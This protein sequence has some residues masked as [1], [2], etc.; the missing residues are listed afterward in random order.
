MISSQPFAINFKAG[1]VSKP[2]NITH[3]E[4]FFSVLDCGVAV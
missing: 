3:D 2:Q 4:A 1:Q